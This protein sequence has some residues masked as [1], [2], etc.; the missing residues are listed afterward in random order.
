MS[1]EELKAAHQVLGRI[2][3]FLFTLHAV[4]YL[5]FFV[6]SGFLAKRLRDIDVIFGIISV[7]LFSILGTTA[8]GQ[9]RK[10]NY[11]VFYIS[12][13]AIANLIIV[14]LYIHVTHVRPYVWQVVLVNVIHL[15][16]RYWGL[17]SYS[18]TV[19][20]TP[21]TNLV[22]LRIPLKAGEAALKWRPGQHVYLSR[23]SG[24]SSA[25]SVAGQLAM[26]CQTN[27]FT[28]ASLPSK[29][30]ELLLVA[31]TLN[32]NTKHLA[33]LAQSLSTSGLDETPDV[34]LA[35]EGAYG[36]STRLPEVSRF[37]RILFVAGG[38]GATYILP[39]Y[40]NIV[41]SGD[42]AQPG[43][44]QIRLVWAVRKLAEAS[45]AFDTLENSETIGDSESSAQNSIEVFVTRPSGPDLQAGGA[46]DEI[47]MAEDEQLLSLEEQMQKPRKGIELHVG[48]PALSAIV[49]E[50][51]SKSSRVAVFVCGPKGM[52]EQLGDAVEKWVRNGHDVYWHDERF[53]W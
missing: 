22:Q 37:G 10:W 16:L 42:V 18:G 5:N 29:D 6:V 7:A 44:P 15:L 30:K 31:R 21:G 11:R 48:R 23:P 24:K 27:P 3:L 34:Q 40:R 51:F 8:L 1:H 19:K 28:I 46:D 38:V 49:D 53:G 45:W 41:E 36:S 17:K 12:H 4:F 9:L 26:T 39:I 20:L 52:S 13:V 33:A 35:L 50:V 47:E 25:E 43:G 14:P 2:V 32:G